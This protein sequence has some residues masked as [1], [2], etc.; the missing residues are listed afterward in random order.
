[1]HSDDS[2]VTLWMRQLMAGEVDGSVQR[3]WERYYVRLVK[4]ARVKLGNCPRRIADEEDVAL[5]AFE[6]FRQGAAQ[7]RFPQLNDR[8]DLWRLLVTITARKAYKLRLRLSRKKRGGNAVLD[9]AALKEAGYDSV[10]AGLDQFLSNE[11]SPEFA[12]QA[13]EEYQRLITLLPRPEL[14]AIAQMKMQGFTNKE[15]AQELDC[16]LRS[17]ERRL[18]VIRSLWNEAETVT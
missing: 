13:A 1:M 16:A 9:E 3:L 11:P 4:L 5:S 10:N 6:S 17:V 18:R 12:A 7:A 14:R 2:T 15:I 8:D